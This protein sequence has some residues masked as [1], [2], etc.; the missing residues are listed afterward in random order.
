MEK[1]VRRKLNKPA[2]FL[3]T[4]V[5]VSVFLFAVS[6][7]SNPPKAPS[8]STSSN[9]LAQTDC[10]VLPSPT[11]YY[12][13]QA[14]GG[15][16]QQAQYTGQQ[17]ATPNGTQAVD[18]NM[19]QGQSGFNT[20]TGQTVAGQSFGLQQPVD[21]TS[22]YAPQQNVNTQYNSQ[23][24]SSDGTAVSTGNYGYNNAIASNT[25]YNTTP[26]GANSNIG[27]FNNPAPCASTTWQPSTSVGTTLDQ[28][29]AG[30]T[31]QGEAGTSGSSDGTAEIKTDLKGA[32]V[33]TTKLREA[34]D[35]CITS[36]SAVGG[37]FDREAYRS[38]LAGLP[39][40]TDNIDYMSFCRAQVVWDGVC[41][42]DSIKKRYSAFSNIDEI[43]FVPENSVIDQCIVCEEAS[44]DKQ[45]KI[46]DQSPNSKKLVVYFAANKGDTADPLPFDFPFEAN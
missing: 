46:L 32:A 16:T 13:G 38:Y 43:F 5:N 34:V 28:T 37:F 44:A 26:T 24:L 29:P 25:G 40:P 22:G 36:D 14:A 7:S 2:V 30:G 31:Q 17:Q 8:N 15:M 19:Q 23:V 33:G 45:C 10:N 4:V 39:A 21:T 27:T 9:S 1:V 12:G 42:F 11:P 18:P 6:C 41:D 35:A 3:H 20:A